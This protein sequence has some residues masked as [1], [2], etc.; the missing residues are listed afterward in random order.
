[1]PGDADLF[2]TFESCSVTKSDKAQCPEFNIFQGNE[3]GF[4]G[5]SHR[6]SVNEDG[7]YGDC[8]SEGS[9]SFNTSTDRPGKFGLGADVTVDSA[10]PVRVRTDFVEGSKNLWTGWRTSA[11]NP[12]RNRVSS[13]NRDCPYLQLSSDAAQKGMAFA[14]KTGESEYAD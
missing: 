10:L 7:S 1:M 5:S 12:Q 6:C 11:R 13:Y 4:A 9:C 14:F 3:Y 8:D 2:G